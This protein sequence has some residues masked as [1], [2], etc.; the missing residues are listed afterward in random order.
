MID[1][2]V[3]LVTGLGYLLGWLFSVVVVLALFALLI[4]GVTETR[5]SVAASVTAIGFFVP[6]L[7]VASTGDTGL[8]AVVSC[9]LG[10]MFGSLWVDRS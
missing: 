4:A 2:L 3:T 10:L 6:T 8:V 1:T 5:V 7:A 9:L